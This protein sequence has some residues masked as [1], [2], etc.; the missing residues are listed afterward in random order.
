MYCTVYNDGS[1][2]VA[3]EYQPNKK[4]DFDGKKVKKQID[5]VELL[6]EELYLQAVKQGLSYKKQ[7][8]F[9]RAE[10]S[11]T[12]HIEKVLD[13]IIDEGFRRKSANIA[14]RKKIIP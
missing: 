2:Y 9:V 5:N 3:Y 1:N 13:K 7:Q 4:R 10:L 12:V 6:F 14:A 11:K 8:E